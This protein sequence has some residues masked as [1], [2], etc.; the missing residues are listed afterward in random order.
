MNRSATTVAAMHNAE[1]WPPPVL[2]GVRVLVVDDDDETREFLVALLT[3]ARADVRS[4]ASAAEALTILNWW[5]P[6]VLVSDIGMPGQDGYSLIR[7]VRELPADR[8]RKLP[9]AAVTA[10]SAD[11]DRVKALSAGFQAHLAKPV[12]PDRLL[13][14]LSGLARE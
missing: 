8:K 1:Q 14:V 7:A 13:A 10:F 2:G 9:A 4:A 12:D 11:A 5:W 3:G 6:G